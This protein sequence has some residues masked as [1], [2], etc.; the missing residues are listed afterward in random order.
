M[1]VS[2]RLKQQQ[3]D[4]QN[5]LDDLLCCEGRVWCYVIIK[6][7]GG[8]VLNVYTIDRFP[9]HALSN[10]DLELCRRVRFPL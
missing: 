1:W 3:L 7:H 10:F 2:T 4:M 8:S 6:L 9:L 5:D